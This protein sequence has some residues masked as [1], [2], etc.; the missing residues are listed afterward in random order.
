MFKANNDYPHRYNIPSKESILVKQI[1]IT[2]TDTIF[3]LK[4]VYWS[5]K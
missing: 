4:K 1:M 2:H 3:H 5:S